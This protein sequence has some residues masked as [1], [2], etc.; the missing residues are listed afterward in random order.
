[1]SNMC[2]INTD[3]KRGYST[4][5]PRLVDSLPVRVPK[6]RKLINSSS[7]RR[8]PSPDSSPS[9][10]SISPRPE[11]DSVV[12]TRSPRPESASPMA[13][14]RSFSPDVHDIDFAYSP[15]RSVSPE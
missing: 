8:S 7:H 2:H 13:N 15:H 12:E 11:F 4:G 6:K 14:F 9:P 10:R 3:R 1:M 5:A